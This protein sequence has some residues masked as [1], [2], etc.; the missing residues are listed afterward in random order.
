MKSTPQVIRKM[1][2]QAIVQFPNKTFQKKSTASAFSCHLWY[3]LL[4][5]PQWDSSHQS[6]RS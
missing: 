1:V 3:W 6:P 4:S 5:E 2:E